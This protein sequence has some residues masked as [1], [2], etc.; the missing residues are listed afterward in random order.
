ML[1]LLGEYPSTLDAKGRALLPAALKKQLGGEAANGFV[2]NRDVFSQCLVLYPMEE[3]N[4]T[5]AEVRQRTF[6]DPDAVS[7]GDYHVCKDVGWAL[8]G[9]PFD[10][11][12]M[13]AYLEPWRPQRGRVRALLGLAGLRRP[14]P[15]PTSAVNVYGA[16][17]TPLRLPPGTR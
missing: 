1:N 12:E 17:V 16:T 2:V 3:W 15:G 6:G 11:A 5:S 9:T 13:E 8:T 10:D 7:F 14:R 4:R